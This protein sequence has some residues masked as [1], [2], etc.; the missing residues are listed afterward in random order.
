MT[1]QWYGLRLI[2]FASIVLKT[3]ITTKENRINF[4]IVSYLGLFPSSH[5]LCFLTALHSKSR[6]LNFLISSFT[7]FP[8]DDDDVRLSAETFSS[9][10]PFS[11]F[12]VKSSI[13]FTCLAFCASSLFTAVDRSRIS[14]RNSAEDWV[15]LALTCCTLRYFCR[16]SFKLPSSCFVSTSEYQVSHK[17]LSTLLSMCLFRWALL[18]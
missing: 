11:S 10:A 14:S 12:L 2:P 8:A 4:L 15:S 3:M 1:R 7:R 9:A 17:W 18:S 16:R 5:F 13:C 6:V